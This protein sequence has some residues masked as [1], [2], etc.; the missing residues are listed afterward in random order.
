[1][2]NIFTFLLVLIAMSAAQKTFAQTFPTIYASVASGSWATLTTRQT[3]TGNATITRGIM[4]TGTPATTVHSGPYYI[5]ISNTHTVTMG[6]GKNCMVTPN[7][8][9]YR[10]HLVLGI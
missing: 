1:M 10:S 3:F 5:Y 9:G 4:N 6:T 7:Q 2:K 8:T